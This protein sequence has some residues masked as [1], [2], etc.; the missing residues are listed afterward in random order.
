[1]SPE[2]L[3]V[4]QSGVLEV[5]DGH[6]LAWETVGDPS[7]MAAIYLHGGPGSGFSVGQRAF[8]GEHHGVLFDQRGSGRSTPSAETVENLSDNTT[9][10]LIAD[11][12]TLRTHL[13]IERWA[14]LG[15]S[16][17]TTLALAYAQAHP[18]RVVGLV[19]GL[20]TTTTRAEVDWITVEMGRVFPEEWDTFTGVIPEPL[21]HLRPVEAYAEMLFDPDLAATA[22]AAW[23]TWEDVHMSLAP[24][25]T[26]SLSIADPTFQLRFARMV[27]HYWANAA[28]LEPGQILENMDRLASIPGHMIHGRYDVSSPLSIA[29]ALHKVWPASTLTV[30]EDAGH[31]G[32][33]LPDLVRSAL[34]EFAGRD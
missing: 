21:S 20:V 7:A 22:A 19:L 29:W 27:T 3:P 18:D 34:R 26:P 17:G 12:E 8:V 1:M 9:H 24:G 11:I 32:A 16:W 10:K 5:G 30:M 4:L 25:A 15:L 23:C 13:G 33:D 14:V 2:P 6:R 31:G 28:F